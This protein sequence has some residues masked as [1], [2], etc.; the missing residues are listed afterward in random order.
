MDSHPSGLL[1][2]PCLGFPLDAALILQ[3]QNGKHG[4][5]NAKFPVDYPDSFS[6]KTGR[7]FPEKTNFSA[8]LDERQRNNGTGLLFELDFSWMVL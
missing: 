4:S 2:L 8:Y 3:T 5:V 1:P 6:P 7:L